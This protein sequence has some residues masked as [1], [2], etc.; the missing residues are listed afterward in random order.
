MKK[1]PTD[2][3]GKFVAL[4]GTFQSHLD[5]KKRTYRWP[6]L[7]V[8]P[9][10]AV[11][12]EGE[13]IEIPER[14]EDIK[15]GSELTAV[16]GESIY[17]ASEAEAWDAIKGFTISNDVTAAGDWPG[18]SDPD[19]GM[20]TGVGYKI[21]PTFSPILTKYVEKQT[22]D[23]YD[24]LD[25]TVSVDGQRSVEGSTAQLS[26]TIPELVSFASNVV[27]LNENDVIALGDP[28]E[29]S[30]LLDEASSVTCTVENIGEL[31]N[32]IVRR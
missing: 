21:L 3:I 28:G 26:F 12:G 7:W 31:T 22:M 11:V 29:P 16:I 14:V 9:P 1:L 24:D 20:I 19:H 18:W 4:G 25:V 23:H 8:V 17:E 2:S 30:I 27:K 6:D 32:P 5:E 13:P 15:P 10:E